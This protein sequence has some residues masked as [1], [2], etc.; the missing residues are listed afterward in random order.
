MAFLV[1]KLNK[2]DRLSILAETSDV[3]K[4]YADIP[5]TEFRTTEGSLS[6]WIIESL[7]KINEA[8]LAIAI[9][10][11]KISK[12]DFIII[13]TELL[14]KYQLEFKQ[15]YAGE[16][17]AVPDLQDTHYDILNISVEKLAVCTKVY[18]AIVCE[19]PDCEK[20]IVRLA[21]GEVKDILREAFENNR[22]DESKI[23]SNLE[24]ELSKLKAG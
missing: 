18:Q 23:P 16:D 17:I 21:A 11:S 2:M 24:K 3:N 19:D 20:Y 6:T 12:M 1:R 7:D 9:T 14:S 8:V 5:T 22:I 4:I 10:S 15:T 13:D